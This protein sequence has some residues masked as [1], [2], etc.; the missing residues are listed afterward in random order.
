MLPT[1]ALDYRPALLSSAGIGRVVREL[2][3]ALAARGECELHLFAHSLARAARGDGVP[4]GAHLHRLPIPGRSLPWLWRIGCGADRLAGHAQV[5]HWTDYVHPRPSRAR[6]VLTIHDLAFAHDASWHGE[7][8]A[9]LLDRTRRAAA[10]AAAVIVPS[11]ATAADVA[12]LLP[13]SPPPRVIPFAADH[14][15][16]APRLP[17]P[18][19]GEPYLLCLGTI[20]PRKNH[21]TLLAA[22]RRL[23]QPR[24]R[25]VVVGRRGWACEQ[26]TAALRAAGSDG[27]RWLDAA[28]DATTL[29]LLQ[30]AEALLY[31]SLWEG[32]GLPPLEAMALGVPV[33]TGDSAALRELTDGAALLCDCRETEALAA[34]L[35]RLLGDADLRR[36]LRE[37]GRRRAAAF[38]WSRCAAAHAA[39]YREVVA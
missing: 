12:R 33:L 3:T 32:F 37:Q 11:H 2:A 36:Q 28:D 18:F 23:P 7:Q 4:A 22:W 27:V 29:A 34:A 5:L 39:V 16:R 17:L 20:E 15:L 35:Q 24:P 21:L 1:V 19:G 31:P 10:L 13:E 9:E 30:H 6:I 38:S 8:A 14:V 26:I 25:L